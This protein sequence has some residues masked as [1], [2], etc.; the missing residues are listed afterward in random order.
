MSNKNNNSS[1]SSDLHRVPFYRRP[2]FLIA[3]AI[4][5]VVVVIIIIVIFSKKPEADNSQETPSTSFD[6]PNKPTTS[7]DTGDSG[8]DS[9]PDQ[10]EEPA[11]VLQYEGQDPNKLDELTGSIAY[12][13]VDRDAGTLTITASIDQYLQSTGECK[14]R[15]TNDGRELYSETLPAT[16]DVTTSVCGPFEAP[17]SEL[18]SGTI[19]IEITIT[20]DNKSGT[21]TDEVQI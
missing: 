20:A 11:G 15:L 10:S 19:K 21:I 6:Q 9:N 5:L 18:G 7:D 4:I 3:G 2:P 16:A 1:S 14:L 17:L 8:S 12:R 13:G